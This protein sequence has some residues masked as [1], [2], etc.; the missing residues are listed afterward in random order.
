MGAGDLV[1]DF[2][3]DFLQAPG[4]AMPNEGTERQKT[5]LN[6]FHFNFETTA[7]RGLP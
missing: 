1:S 2:D 5:R 6:V 7:I 3:A 4:R